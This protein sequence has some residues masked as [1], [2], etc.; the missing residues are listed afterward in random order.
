MPLAFRT[1]ATVEI[2]LDGDA[3]IPRASRPVF[4]ARHATEAQAQ[5]MESLFNEQKQDE[6]DKTYAK[7]REAL[8]VVLVGWKNIPGEYAGAD[9]LK[10]LTQMEILELWQSV[11]S[12]SI[13]VGPFV[14]PSGSRSS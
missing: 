7:L 5:Q 9:S 1:N 14:S 10:F 8:A 2:W 12:Q 3:E 13:S 4:I 11:W 6:R